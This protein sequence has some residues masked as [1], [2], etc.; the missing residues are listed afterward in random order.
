MGQEGGLALLASFVAFGI[1]T[2]FLYVIVLKPTLTNEA[3][4]DSTSGRG[5]TNTGNVSQSLAR[6]H[7]GASLQGSERGDPNGEIGQLME[8]SH[9]Q[10]VLNNCATSPSFLSATSR[11]AGSKMLVDGLIPFRYTRAAEFEQS[12]SAEGDVAA[13]NRKERAR[14]LSRL[15]SL[16]VTGSHSTTPPSR[17]SALVVSI[18]AEDVRCLKLRRIIYLFATYYNLLVILGGLPAETTTDDFA[19][20][21]AQLRGP[22]GEKETLCTEILPDHRIVAASTT[23]GRIAFVRQLARVELVLEFQ[24]AVKTDLVRFGYRVINY[25]KSQQSDKKCSQLSWSLGGGN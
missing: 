24:E 25:G 3:I 19:S 21:R 9:I 2:F 12:R 16:D 13:Q 11:L 8:D 23:T 22:D 6:G 5:T 18:P 20:L 14:L 1:I 7:R 15:L 17:G 4:A 10:R